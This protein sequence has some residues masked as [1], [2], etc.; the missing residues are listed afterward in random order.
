VG[1]QDIVEGKRE[2]RA[3]MARVK[4]LPPGY[5]IVYQEIQK[6]YFKVAP[7]DPH[8]LG[9]L[10]DFFEQSAADGKDVRE[11]VGDDVAAFADELIAAA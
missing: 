9:D 8:V 2:W 3:H 5:R 1:I 4:A 11:L 6:Y 7:A 10:I